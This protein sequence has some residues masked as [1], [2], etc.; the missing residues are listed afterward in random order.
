MSDTLI[1]FGKIGEKVKECEFDW[2]W[3]PRGGSSGHEVYGV[4]LISRLSRFV[5]KHELKRSKHYQILVNYLLERINDS[6]CCED[7][8]IELGAGA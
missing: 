5:E 7:N 8:R 2:K 1:E 4:P 3:F 6:F